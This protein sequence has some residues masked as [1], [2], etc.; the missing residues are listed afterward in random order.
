VPWE[1]WTS[2]VLTGCKCSNFVVFCADCAYTPVCCASQD[3]DF[4]LDASSLAWISCSFSSVTICVLH[5]LLGT[6]LHA[7]HQHEFAHRQSACVCHSWQQ[8]ALCTLVPLWVCNLFLLE[9]N[10]WTHD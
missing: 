5:F 4:H 1:F 10:T 3:S 6:F 2:A 8:L 7:C 9:N